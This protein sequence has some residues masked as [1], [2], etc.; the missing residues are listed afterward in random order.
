MGFVCCVPGCFN[1]A[2]YRF[3][4]DKKQR[5]QWVL[6]INRLEVGSKYKLFTPDNTKHRVCS[7]HFKGGKKTA[8]NNVPT[9]FTGR[10]STPTQ[11]NTRTSTKSKIETVTKSDSPIPDVDMN[12]VHS[13]EEPCENSCT[14]SPMQTCGLPAAAGPSLL[15]AT[16]DFHDHKVLFF[17]DALNTPLYVSLNHGEPTNSDSNNKVINQNTRRS[18]LA[19]VTVPPQRSEVDPFTFHTPPKP[20]SILVE[21]PASTSTSSTKKVVKPTV[22]TDKGTVTSNKA[23]R[24]VLPAGSCAP[25]QSN[26]VE[27]PSFTTPKAKSNCK[28]LLPLTPTK[29][30]ISRTHDHTYCHPASLPVTPKKR[31][32]MGDLKKA[33]TNVFTLRQSISR[34][35]AEVKLLNARLLYIDVVITLHGNYTQALSR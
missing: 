24:I 27:L 31:K 23:V 32:L 28:Q 20:N 26:E 35:R 14:T 13:A 1:K 18:L 8:T 30:S 16:T 22:P 12:T 6:N 9:I 21:I 34:A 19:S 2:V 29:Y 4:E 25:L 5:R 33:T 11:R 17:V 7:D 3:P 15:P 10:D